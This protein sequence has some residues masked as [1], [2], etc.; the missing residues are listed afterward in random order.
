M[1]YVKKRIV[2]E[3]EVPD[4]ATHYYVERRI[5]NNS[6]ELWG[7]IEGVCCVW[8]TVLKDWVIMPCK[9]LPVY[10]KPI[11]VIE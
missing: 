3:A 9:T 7:V 4:G 5:Q 11:E 8:N 10:L 1:S 2:I 6:V